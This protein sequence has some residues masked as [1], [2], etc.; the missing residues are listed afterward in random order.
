[1]V[2]YLL[3]YWNSVIDTIIGGTTYTAEFFL[4]IGRA[5]AGALGGVLLSALKLFYDFFAT[6]AYILYGIGDILSQ[7][8][9]PVG[10]FFNVLFNSIPSPTALS[11]AT[12]TITE[13]I[14]ASKSFIEA[15]LPQSLSYSTMWGV[16]YAVTL[17]F[18]FWLFIKSFKRT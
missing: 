5:V 18:L 15:I 13:D 17:F 12:S 3:G 10:F 8:F 11:N 1:M 9:K 6:I 16:I 2:E 14:D 4:N 7:I